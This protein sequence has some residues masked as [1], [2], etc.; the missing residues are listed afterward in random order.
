MYIANRNIFA[1]FSS[2]YSFFWGKK[3]LPPKQQVFFHL[4]TWKG[5]YQALRTTAPFILSH[6]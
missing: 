3:M 4:S 6:I 2:T 1:N 5:A